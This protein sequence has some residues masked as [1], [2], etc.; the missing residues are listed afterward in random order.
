MI[1]HN[2][3]YICSSKPKKE[4]KSSKKRLKKSMDL[5]IIGR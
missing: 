5:K 1:T 3:A 4:K 2:F